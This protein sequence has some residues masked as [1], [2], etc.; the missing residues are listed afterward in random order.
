VGGGQGRE[1]TQTMY[2]RMNKFLKKK[3]QKIFK[4]MDTENS[5]LNAQ[6]IV[7]KGGEIKQFLE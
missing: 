4:H 2:A 6:W 1:M 5:P 3:L 7:K